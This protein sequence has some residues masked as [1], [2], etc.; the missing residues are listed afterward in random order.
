M[1]ATT[2]YIA[3]ERSLLRTT[4]MISLS[5]TNMDGQN[6]FELT[7]VQEACAPY[8]IKENDT[9]IVVTKKDK[10]RVCA[11]V[12]YTEENDAAI[13][14]ADDE[15]AYTTTISRESWYESH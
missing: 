15:M 4:Q 13:V 7:D 12:P 1:P 8:D 11:I 5:P 2:L 10:S 14:V 9:V 3:V 6:L